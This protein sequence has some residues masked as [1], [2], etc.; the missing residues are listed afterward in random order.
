MGQ[1]STSNVIPLGSGKTLMTPKYV[2]NSETFRQLAEEAYTIPFDQQ[3]YTQCYVVKTVAKVK[4]SPLKG[5]PLQTDIKQQLVQSGKKLPVAIQKDLKDTTS[6]LTL[7][8][9]SSSITVHLWVHP[10]TKVSS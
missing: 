6:P 4:L 3:L 8:F 5:L 10:K 9:G 1:Y 2:S 7:L